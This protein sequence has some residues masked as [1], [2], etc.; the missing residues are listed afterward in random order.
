MCEPCVASLE[1]G[2]SWMLCHI[3]GPMKS[4]TLYGSKKEEEK[5]LTR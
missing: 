4:W 2:S 5:P 3:A 1:H